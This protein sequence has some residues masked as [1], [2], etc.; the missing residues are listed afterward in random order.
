MNY[1]LYK[2]QFDTAVHFGPSDSALSLY[3]SEDHFCADTLFSALCHTAGAL[4]G[5]GAIE[6]LCTLAESGSLLLSDAMPWK[7]DSLYIP[8]PC[9]SGE[10]NAEV[11][12]ELRKAVK[13]LVYI[14]VSR[15]AEF[16]ASVH[17]DGLFY[18][19]GRK[20]RFGVHGE[21]T[22]ACITPGEDAVPYQVGFYHFFPGC[23]LWL[24]AGCAD[25]EQGETLKKLLTLL[26]LSGIGGETSSGYGKFHIAD[27]ILLNASADGQLRWLQNALEDTASRRQ[28]LLSTSLPGDDELTALLPEAEY[29][30]TRRGGFVQSDCYSENSRKKRAQY[31]LSAGSVLP[32]R[33]APRLYSV[34]TEGNHPVYRFSGPILLGVAL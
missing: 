22:K 8:K 3:S 18:G 9:V 34:G 16:A 26:G 27:C 33:F 4:E 11:P 21:S 15:F 25:R 10:S 28:L 31:F 5:D 20:V 23:G 1:Y 19:E 29:R 6:K 7:G 2:L 17:G 24:I 13:K 12:A 30:L 32:A 14:P